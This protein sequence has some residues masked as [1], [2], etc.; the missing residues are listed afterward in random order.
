[1][2]WGDMEQVLLRVSHEEC[3][4]AANL[5]CQIIKSDPTGPYDRRPTRPPGP[6]L[7]DSYRAHISPEGAVVTTDKRYW[8][9]VEYGI[10]R[11]PA[12]PHIRPAI[13]QI[14]ALFG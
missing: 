11:G 2:T 10:G 12:Q 1:M 7:R 4:K 5:L 14:R 9:Y 6:H 13:E 3:I 8:L